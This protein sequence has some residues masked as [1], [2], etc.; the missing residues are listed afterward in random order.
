[1]HYK[2]YK[3]ILS[4]KNGMNIYRGCTHGCIYCDSRSK[5]YHIDHDFEDIE[6]KTNAPQILEDALMRRRQKC[7]VSTGA[8]TDPYIHLEK[9]IGYTRQCLEVIAKHGFGLG[10][11]TKSALILRDLELLKRINEKAK[12][13]VE[14]TLTTFDE[15]LCAI[16]EPHV[17]TTKER[18]ETL[19]ILNENGIATVVW[20]S[21]LL[22]FINDTVENVQGILDY[23]IAAKVHAILFFGAGVTMREGNREYFYQQLDRHFPGMKRRYMQAFGNQYNCDS[24]NGQAISALVHRTCKEHG[25]LCGTTS[26]FEYLHTFETKNNQEQLTFSF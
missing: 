5:C 4:P 18:F 15:A 6:I 22:P 1:M 16:V 8:M 10:I 2:E 26:V 13:V 21:P 20:L 23:C 3:N 24:P 12:V 7:M 19:K 17:S 9:D 11:Q 25:I 14:M